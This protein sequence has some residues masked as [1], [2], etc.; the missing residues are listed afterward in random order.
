[1]TKPALDEAHPAKSL[2]LIVLAPGADLGKLETVEGRESVLLVY[3]PAAAEA[4]WLTAFERNGIAIA[5]VIRAA[6]LVSSAALR[7]RDKY[8]R[9]IAEWP[10]RIQKNKKSFKAFFTYRDE[11]ALWWLSSAS[12]KDNEISPVF[13]VLCDWEIIREVVSRQHFNECVV[14]G[15]DRE[16]LSMVKDYCTRRG[17]IFVGHPGNSPRRTRSVFYRL[18]ARAWFTL[19]LIGKSVLFRS[20]LRPPRGQEPRKATI[21]FLSIFP[22]V[23]ECRAGLPYDR[24]YRDLPEYVEG[25]VGHAALVCEYQA[26]PFFRIEEIRQIA[27]MRRNCAKIWFL[28]DY[29]RL[30]DLAAVLGNL[31][32]FARYWLLDNLSSEFRRSFEYDGVDAYCLIGREFR[33]LFLSNEVP[34]HILVSRLSERLG[35]NA[36]FSVLVS[37]LELYPF[38]RAVY[39]GLRRAR[40]STTILAYQHANITRMKLWYA[41]QPQE[42]G[43]VGENPP[44]FID[45]MPTPD[46]YVFQGQ[47]GKRLVMESGYPE[48]RCFVTGSPRYDDLAELVRKTEAAE[49]H[50][51]HIAAMAGS[52]KLALVIPSLSDEDANELIDVVLEAC[53]GRD[54]CFVAVKPHPLCPVG[55]IVAQSSKR[56]GFEHATVVRDD[57]H[58][59]IMASDVVLTTYSTAGD[60]AIA[61]GK[62][63][64]CYAGVRP[65]MSSYLDVEA[66]PIVHD[67]IELEEALTRMLYDDE[68]RS[69][70]LARRDDLIAGSFYKLDGRA[71]QRFADTLKYLIG[72][73]S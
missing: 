44:R 36:S 70:Y 62:P 41:Y 27:R 28:E 63:V 67:S 14:F 43:A 51:E 55:R 60:E 35:S 23:L 9:F 24:N 66:A 25:S 2:S 40:P 3:L 5:E 54:D 45:S 46:Y 29:V 65:T 47:M 16:L 53:S 7:A 19:M 64:I 12:M 38:A 4:A 17:M 22:L 58:D 30:S 72:E 61:I 15:G 56:H 10:N 48:A 37:F 71:K 73:A 31:G 57:L 20:I 49:V 13:G 26:R 68:Y 59:L 1:M 50:L 34:H 21:A 39:Y 8:S 11:I 42:L 69:R 6:E 52:R 32:F 33:N 18:L